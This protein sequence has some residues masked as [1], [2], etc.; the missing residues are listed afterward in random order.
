MF[1]YLAR[2]VE[3]SGFEYANTVIFTLFIIITIVNTSSEL[4]TVVI[5]TS[6]PVL[7]FF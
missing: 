4:Q 7:I 5:D 6:V 3:L 2:A 1:Y